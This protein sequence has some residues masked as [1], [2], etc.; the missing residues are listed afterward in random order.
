MHNDSTLDKS[1]LNN[2]E[3]VHEQMT[4]KEDWKIQGLNELINENEWDSIYPPMQWQIPLQVW[5]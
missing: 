1:A 3:K 2:W 5:D 4:H